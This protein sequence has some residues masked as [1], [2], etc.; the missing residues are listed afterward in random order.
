MCKWL[1]RHIG[2]ASYA[3]HGG[4]KNSGRNRIALYFR[5]PHDASA[6]PDLEVADGT[7]LPGYYSPNAPHGYGVTDD[8]AAMCNL[9][10]PTTAQEAMR[11]LF[12]GLELERARWGMS[13]P[14]SVV[15][16]ERE[17]GVTNIRNQ[18]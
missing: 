10:S 11:R 3:L 1:D 7:I 15:K 6:F 14:L 17:P 16:T 13:S 5:C 8:E 4:G 9:Y 2:N 18:P 12:A